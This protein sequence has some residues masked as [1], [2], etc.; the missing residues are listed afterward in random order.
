ME[1]VESAQEQFDDVN[2]GEKKKKESILYPCIYWI[3]SRKQSMN[4]KVK[5]EKQSVWLLRN[6]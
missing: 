5:Q 6:R 2:R 3:W 4:L 1:K